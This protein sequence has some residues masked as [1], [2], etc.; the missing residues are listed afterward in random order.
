M[1][2][3][4]HNNYDKYLVIFITEIL[5]QI[6]ILG[7]GMNELDIVYRIAY[8]LKSVCADLQSYYI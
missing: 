2:V 8:G 5:I 1:N 6:R 4:V 7:F 3:V